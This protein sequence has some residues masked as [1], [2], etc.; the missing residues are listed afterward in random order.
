MKSIVRFSCVPHSTRGADWNKYTSSCT[1]RRLEEI[2]TRGPREDPV[3]IERI[4]RNGRTRVQDWSVVDI[5]LRLARGEFSLRGILA[6]FGLHNLACFHAFTLDHV[7]SNIMEAHSIPRHSHG[8]N[9]LSLGS[10][11]SV[12][13]LCVGRTW[14][15]RKQ[16]SKKAEYIASF[17]CQTERR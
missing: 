6:A 4:K 10:G 14:Y 1:S 15:S 7:M 9:V 17:F 13:K 11:A 12:A 16:S 5:E 2:V 8:V 3:E